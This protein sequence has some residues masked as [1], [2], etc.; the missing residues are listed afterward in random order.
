MRYEVAE[1]PNKLSTA[2]NLGTVSATNKAASIIPVLRKHLFQ[3]KPAI[4]QF[5]F[6][7]YY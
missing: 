5:K 6:K 1:A 4:V 3:L 7:A 2:S